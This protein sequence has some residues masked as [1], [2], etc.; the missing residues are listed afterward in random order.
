MD[1]R[2]ARAR[3]A[4]ERA[5]AEEELARLRAELHQRERDAGG[6]LG[7]YDQHPAD[8][9]T[10]LAMRMDEE[11]RIEDLEER[12]AA[13]ARAERRLEQGTYGRSVESGVP[14]PDQRLMAVPWAERPV[15]E[16]AA[17][18]AGRHLVVDPEAGVPHPEEVV[19]TPLDEPEEASPAAPPE[20]W[21]ADEVLPEPPTP[22]EEQDDEV[23]MNAP[24]AVYRGEGGPPEVGEDEEDDDVLRRRYRPD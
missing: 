17:R 15:A 5:R 16:E 13:I 6:E 8:S 1:E 3:L 10:E 18:E 20:A 22:P 12:L 2:T 9:G 23:E 7:D 4:E 14:I 21:P 11:R 24:G 19:V